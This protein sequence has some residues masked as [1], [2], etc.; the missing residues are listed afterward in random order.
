MRLI[1]RCIRSVQSGIVIVI[2]G[3][4]TCGFN[5]KQSGLENVLLFYNLC[6]RLTSRVCRPDFVVT[7][8][9]CFQILAITHV[10]TKQKEMIGKL[11]KKEG[12]KEI[13]S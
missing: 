2:L 6:D 10:G 1:N 5:I 7:M 9:P 3:T 8:S 4:A 12:K 13:S 11:T